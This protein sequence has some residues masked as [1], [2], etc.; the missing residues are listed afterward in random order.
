MQRLWG[1]LTIQA[2]EGAA[3]QRATDFDS[4]T[5]QATSQDSFANQEA[6]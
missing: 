6:G 1:F 5:N 2:A 3:S 4:A